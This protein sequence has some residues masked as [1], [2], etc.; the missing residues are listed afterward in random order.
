M[1]DAFHHMLK[2]AFQLYSSVK[3]DAVVGLPSMV[4]LNVIGMYGLD[5]TSINCMSSNKF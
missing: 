2:L 1:K 3:T 5:H 4:L